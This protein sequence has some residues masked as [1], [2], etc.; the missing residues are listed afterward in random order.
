MAAK[1]ETLDEA[2]LGAQRGLLMRAVFGQ[3]LTIYLENPKSLKTW[4]AILETVRALSVDIAAKH[5]DS[6]LIVGFAPKFWSHWEK[7]NIPF[8][9]TVLGSAGKFAYTFGDVLIYVKSPSHEV[10]A[11]ILAPYIPR[12]EAVSESIDTVVV[13][14]RPDARIMGGRYVDSITNPNDPISLTEDILI[15]GGRDPRH[16]GACFGFT[17]KFLFDWPG[18]ASQAA[19]TQDEMIGRN[20]AGAVLPQHALVSHIHRANIRD[21]NGDQ[22]KILRQA[23]PFGSSGNHAGREEGLMFVAFC[24]DQQRFEGILRNLL[25]DRPERPVDKLMTVVQGVSGSYWYIPSA[26]ELKVAAVS[27]PDDVYEDPHWQVASPNGFMFYNAQD[28]LHQMAE[29]RYKGGDPPSPR[30]LSLLART[31]S[32]WRDSWVKRQIFPRL[33]HLAGD[34]GDEKPPSA[35]VPVRKGQANLKTLADLLSHPASAIARANGLLRIEAKELIVGVIPDFTLGRGKEVMPYLSKD[36]TMAAWL[37]GQLNEWSA[38]GHVVPDYERL[39]KVGL[40]GLVHEIRTHL[41]KIPE[42]ERGTDKSAVFYMSCLDSLKGVQGYLRNWASITE[43]RASECTNPADADNMTDISNRLH[44][45]ISHPPK[46]FQD[47]VQLIFSFHCCLHL[48]G[49]LTSLGRL[50]QIL[51]PFLPGT[52][53]DRAQDIIDCLWVKIGENAFVNRAFI[54]DYVTYGTTAVCGVGGNFPQGGGINQWVQ[55]ITVGGYKPTDNDVPEGG[56]NEVT[57]LCLK[58]ARRIPV[59]A[60]TLSLRVYRDMPESF[61]DE[62]ARGILAGGAQPILYND[63]KLCPALLDSG[64]TVTRAWSRNYAADGCYEPMLAGASEFAFNNVATLL[65]LEQTLNQGSTYA[66]AGP[67][68]LRGNKATFRSP[69]ASSITSFAHLQSL[70]LDQL[71]WLVIQCYSTILSSYGNLSDICPSPLLSTLIDGCVTSGRDLTAGG[72]RFHIIAPLCVGMSNTIDSLYAINK[73]VF[74]PATAL[75]T[76]PELL[77]CLINDWGF[78]MREPYESTLSGPADSSERSL[79][80][81]ELRSAALA[82]PKWGSGHAEVDFLGNWVVENTVRLCVDTIRSPPPP[83]KALLEAIKDTQNNPDFDFVVCPGIGTFEGY[84]GDG[85]QCGASAD[86]R[87]SNMPIAS[88][89]SPAPAPQDLPPAPAF[90]NIY[91]SLRSIAFP[92]IEHGLSNASPVDM[93]IPET[94]PLED[95]SRFVKAY[96][97]GEVGGNLLT[98]TCADLDTYT[99]AG[100]DPER[101]NLVRVRMGGWT[102]FYATMFPAHQGQHQRRQFFTPWAEGV[103]QGEREN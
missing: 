1:T 7:C 77:D 58:A 30:L 23:L 38:M 83:I 92:S 45:L 102:E 67:E 86:G 59:N 75:T 50:D 99:K 66:A 101:Y 6:G 34:G 5:P 10:A 3:V 47:A 8:S 84:V 24:N 26:T 65:A 53:L 73:L 93:N 31:F 42:P 89:L 39:V 56:A 87:R 14:K 32:H 21:S 17:Q 27:G 12:L 29:D 9:T 68:Q 48:V 76:L 25:G 94:F 79:R 81:T 51:H 90:R 41:D 74:D 100:E 70:F 62:A 103:T 72:A 2:L 40:G 44:H 78:G 36:E 82:L 35:P 11:Q 97:K 55:Q 4:L 15:G 80:Y 13:G 46:T 16:R 18:I 28:Y 64:P 60:P 69:P 43:T 63:D 61:L 54:Y 85:A 95:L 91:Q 96:A 88:D 37:K 49:E 57:M 52:P 71:S 33:P 20:P 98:L 22:R 19:D